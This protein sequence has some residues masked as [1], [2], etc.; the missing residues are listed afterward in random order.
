MKIKDFLQNGIFRSELAADCSTKEKKKRKN[1]KKRQ[2]YPNT[3]IQIQNDVLPHG[4]KQ[5]NTRHRHECI[6]CIAVKNTLND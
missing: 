6:L 2:K 3:K 1:T 4:M 5:Q